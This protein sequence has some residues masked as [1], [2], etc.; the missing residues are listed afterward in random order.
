VIKSLSKVAMKKEKPD[1]SNVGILKR[2][3]LNLESKWE[4]RYPDLTKRKP[5]PNPP[6]GNLDS[7]KVLAG[8]FIVK[9][10]KNIAL[11]Q[12]I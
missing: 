3:L 4:I 6:H 7:G 9:C 11:N 10:M 1:Y 12:K 2:H 5:I 8:I